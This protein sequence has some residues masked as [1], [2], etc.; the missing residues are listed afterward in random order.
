MTKFNN[1]SIKNSKRPIVKTHTV[2]TNIN[3]KQVD[4]NLQTYQDNNDIENYNVKLN[5]P[6]EQSATSLSVIPGSKVSSCSHLWENKNFPFE[7]SSRIMTKC[8]SWP[9]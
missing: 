7:K 5:S 8:S 1:K 4:V 2:A 9:T 3:S 6:T